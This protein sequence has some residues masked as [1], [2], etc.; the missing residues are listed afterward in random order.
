MVYRMQDLTEIVLL[1]YIFSQQ[2]R[3]GNID[4][5]PYWHWA[6]GGNVKRAQADGASPPSS[7]ADHKPLL[8]K[9]TWLNDND[10]G[11]KRKYANFTRKTGML[12][13]I[14]HY[15]PETYRRLTALDK[16]FKA[17]GRLYAYLRDTFG[18]TGAQLR[19]AVNNTHEAADI[20][21]GTCQAGRLRFDLDP[22]GF[23]TTGKA[24]PR[25]VDCDNP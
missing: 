20:L 22:D 3:I 5:V 23:F 6:E 14:R 7:I 9:R 10:A 1:D 13:K 12:A 17:Q 21:R 16:D 8:I 2:D 11:G 19:Q 25:K 18:L 24:E 15:N 4:Y